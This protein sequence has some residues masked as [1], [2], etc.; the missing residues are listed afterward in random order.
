MSDRPRF[1]T[2]TPAQRGVLIAFVLLFA[3][4]LAWQTWSNR[5]FVPNPQSDEP[6]R[7]PQLLD[8][9]DPNTATLAELSLLPGLGQKRAR[10]ILDYRKEFFRTRPHGIPFERDQDLLK[11]TGIGVGILENLKPYLAFPGP[12]AQAPKTQAPESE[13]PKTKAPSSK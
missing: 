13:A 11:V 6:P 1:Q 5:R 9:I 7:N 10:E 8:R 4:F 2:W 12:T 3:G